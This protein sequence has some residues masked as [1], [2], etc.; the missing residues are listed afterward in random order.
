VI[1]G[2][3][4]VGATAVTFNGVKASFRVLNTGNVVATVPGGATTGLVSV[5]NA[6][7]TTGS[8]DS[9]VVE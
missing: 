8:T 6:G 5:T 2:V 3:H 7:G 9:F 1:Q 4:F